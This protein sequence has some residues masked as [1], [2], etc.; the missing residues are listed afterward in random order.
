[1]HVEPNGQV[2]KVK[3][4][5]LVDEDIDMTDTGIGYE[6]YK[7]AHDEAK[8]YGSRLVSDADVSPA[9][10]R[11][12]R[13]LG[14][15]DNITIRQHPDAARDPETGHLLADGP[16]F[17]VIQPRSYTESLLDHYTKA[18]TKAGGP[19][20]LP[21]RDDLGRIK[22][23]EEQ[24]EFSRF[25]R[26]PGKDELDAIVADTSA[27]PLIKQR[28]KEAILADYER[29][30][31]VKNKR[32]QTVVDQDL[33]EEWIGETSGTLRKFF[34]ADDMLTIR[35]PGG[36]HA[37]VERQKAMM[38]TIG[39]EINRVIDIDIG[40][41]SLLKE[42]NQRRLW[43]QVQS[44][45][46]KEQRQLFKLL[47]NVPGVPRGQLGNSV[48]NI[49]VEE[50]EG[51]LLR[52]SKGANVEAFNKWIKV[53]APEN[54]DGVIRNIWPAEATEW[55]RNL[56]VIRNTLQRRTD[57]R[58]VVGTGTDMNPAGLA[59]TRVIFGP[60]SRAQRFFT[61]ARRKQVRGGAAKASELVTDPEALK[62]FASIRVHRLES[63]AA[64]R[65]VQDLG[66]WDLFPMDIKNWIPGEQSGNK[67]EEF[68]ANNPA[69]R[70]A[71]ADY[72]MYKLSL[73]DLDHEG[74]TANATAI[75]NP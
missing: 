72:V 65:V 49:V 66:G 13:K 43:N 19:R 41:V 75:R 1:V 16:V 31:F 7:S 71:V 22:K 57:R 27:N 32:G 39:A 52:M 37:V 6:L 24:A 18:R 20:L 26:E 73:E 8:S 12:W 25:L 30:V 63:S 34:D 28:F 53:V 67:G 61:A 33:F 68:D 70:K 15:E 74:G 2:W 38:D 46:G 10:E 45:T 47:D 54:G 55:I 58:M 5:R 11:M 51:D 64:A 48:R 60:L 56:K 23:T 50:M 29:A 9:A 42:E 59:L 62:L 69:H 17:E 21:K 36:I 3:T 40:A 35:R 44:L 14:K 4:S